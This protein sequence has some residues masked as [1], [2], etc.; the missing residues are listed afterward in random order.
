MIAIVWIKDT[1]IGLYAEH[2]KYASISW[3]CSIICD[4][5]CSRFSCWF[6]SRRSS[7]QPTTITGTLTYSWS[8]NIYVKHTFSENENANISC[9]FYID[10]VYNS[11]MYTSKCIWLNVFIQK[12]KVTVLTV[13]NYLYRVWSIFFYLYRV[14]PFRSYRILILSLLKSISSPKKGG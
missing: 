1:W 4:I 5:P 14:F 2:S 10:E 12:I 8:S 13:Y 7:L 6:S 11:Q 3:N 9:E